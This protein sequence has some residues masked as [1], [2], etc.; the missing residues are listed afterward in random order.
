MSLRSLF[1]CFN[2]L[3]VVV[4]GLYFPLMHCHGLKTIYENCNF[5]V[6]YITCR[7]LRCVWVFLWIFLFFY[8]LIFLCS[9]WA[10]T[11]TFS[12]IWLEAPLRF[13]CPLFSRFALRVFYLTHILR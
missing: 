4:I 9:P 6:I 10:N 8:L 1:V 11:L 3:P 2:L 5:N 7:I 13:S 12:A